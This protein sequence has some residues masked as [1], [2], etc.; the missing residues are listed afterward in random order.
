M[1][2]HSGDHPDSPI[3]SINLDQPRHQATQADLQPL[4]GESL[5]SQDGAP[6]SSSTLTTA[7]AESTSEPQQDTINESHTNLYASSS[8]ISPSIPT[9]TSARSN[10][11]PS[12]PLHGDPTS[13][14][15]ASSTYARLPLQLSTSAQSPNLTTSFQSQQRHTNSSV[16]SIHSPYR[17]D[18]VSSFEHPPHPTV[19]L[20]SN[21]G[22]HPSPFIT[23]HRRSL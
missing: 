6:Q 23:H 21:S 22:H 16:D 17:P 15:Q 7:A 11:T 4:T 10:Q 8:I 20:N 2:I 1:T 13:L 14:G 3:D 5:L 18:C 19:A 9:T 12:N